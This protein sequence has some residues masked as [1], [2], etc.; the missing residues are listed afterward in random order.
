LL[1][2]GSEGHVLADTLSAGAR[3]LAGLTLLHAACNAGQDTLSLARLGAEVTG[4][5]ISPA[6]IAAATQLAE[7][8]AIPARFVAAD[9]YDW[10]PSAGPEFD[11]VFL[12]YGAL[13][14]MSD[15]DALF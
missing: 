10:L 12:S 6:A 7:D 15:L 4:V 11:L 8:T 5:D 3:P 1:G 2:P 9:L 13:I 14:W